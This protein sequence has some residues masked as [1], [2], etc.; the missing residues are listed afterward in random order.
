MLGIE[1]LTG[2]AQAAAIVGT[3]LGEAIVLYVGYG[4]VM[5]AAGSTVMDAIRG[6]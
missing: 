2:N 1:S 5:A 3:V 6:D 4:A